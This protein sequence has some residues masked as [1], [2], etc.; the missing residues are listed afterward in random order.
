MVAAKECSIAWRDH[1][2]VN[3]S[4]GC[5]SLGA[6]FGAALLEL[7]KFA[8]LGGEAKMERTFAAKSIEQLIRFG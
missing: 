4:L 8:E 3:R 2:P 5:S 7:F 1:A 6:G